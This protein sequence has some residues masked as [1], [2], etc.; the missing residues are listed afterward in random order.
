[1]TAVIALIRADWTI[2]ARPITHGT[3]RSLLRK[4][5][6]AKDRVISL[7]GRRLTA[8]LPAQ[9][10]P[11]QNG[12][13]NCVKASFQISITAGSSLRRENHRGIMYLLSSIT[14]STGSP[15]RSSRRLLPRPVPRLALLSL[16]PRESWSVPLQ[17]LLIFADNYRTA[18]PPSMPQRHVKTRLENRSVS[19][20]ELNCA[21]RRK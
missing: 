16:N 8:C 6:L 2:F 18:Y 14:G 11:E 1:M 12:S 3:K 21:F 19:R 13:D 15:S 5:I 4:P 9:C 17:Q 10:F 20:G 7:L